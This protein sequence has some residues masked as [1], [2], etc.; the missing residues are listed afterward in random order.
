MGNQTILNLGLDPST[1]YVRGASN[2]LCLTYSLLDHRLLSLGI[3]Q[4]Q[5]WWFS[6]GLRSAALMVGLEELRRLF[7]PKYQ[8]TMISHCGD[9]GNGE[10][11]EVVPCSGREDL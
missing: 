8:N 7:Q 11:K 10:D 6:G 2:R 5:R 1:L 4:M 3:L 9:F